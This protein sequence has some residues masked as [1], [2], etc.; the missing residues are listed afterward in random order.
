MCLNIIIQ[1]PNLSLLHNRISLKI[2]RSWRGRW[3]GPFGHADSYPNTRKKKR[4]KKGWSMESLNDTG[5]ALHVR[6]HQCWTLWIKPIFLLCFVNRCQQRVPI[7]RVLCF[8]T[9]TDKRFRDSQAGEPV[10]LLWHTFKFEAPNSHQ[11]QLLRPLG[12]HRKL[13]C[14]TTNVLNNIGHNLK[15][16][17]KI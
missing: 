6:D 15:A 14:P 4:K 16:K 5:L 3:P 2:A 11:A 8:S 13:N 7:M 12:H 9:W 1:T 17:G 10:F